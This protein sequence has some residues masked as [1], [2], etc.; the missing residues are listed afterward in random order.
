MV[1]LYNARH[2]GKRRCFY[3]SHLGNRTVNTARH[4]LSTPNGKE[5]G[6]LLDTMEILCPI[7][8]GSGRLSEVKIKSTKE[9]GRGAVQKKK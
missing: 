3:L 7:F 1:A 6:L 9:E 2:W 8:G 4:L 5:E